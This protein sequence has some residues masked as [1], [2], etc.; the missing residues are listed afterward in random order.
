ML[1][2]GR[3][4]HYYLNLGST[5][6]TYDWWKTRCRRKDKNTKVPIPL[7]PEEMERVLESEGNF[8]HGF[9]L[10]S[11]HISGSAR[12]QLFY[13]TFAAHCHGLSKMGRDMFAAYGFCTPHTSFHRLRE[14]IAVQAQLKIR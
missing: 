1:T 9:V 2:G 11:I 14:D 13:P 8:F 6:T 7:T 5:S 3:L 12:T 4:F 10:Q